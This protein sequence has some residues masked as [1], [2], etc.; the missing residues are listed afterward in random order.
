LAWKSAWILR[1]Q[2]PAQSLLDT[3]VS[4]QRLRCCYTG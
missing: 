2:A 1:G 3:A 4:M